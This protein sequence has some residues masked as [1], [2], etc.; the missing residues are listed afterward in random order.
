MRD[1]SRRDGIDIIP[2]MR[3]FT[4]R[5]ALLALA[6]AAA[7]AGWGCAALDR[8]SYSLVIRKKDHQYEPPMAPF[9]KEEVAGNGGEPQPALDLRGRVDF[10]APLEAF[11]PFKYCYRHGT[12]HVAESVVAVAAAPAEY[13]LAVAANVGYLFVTG[14]VKEIGALISLLIPKGP[15]PPPLPEAE[16]DPSKHAC[17]LKK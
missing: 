16:K 14:T 15:D 11:K 7:S 9:P 10:C 2:E 1:G 6:A 13:P 12:S 8:E 3:L 17:Q 4:R 5:R